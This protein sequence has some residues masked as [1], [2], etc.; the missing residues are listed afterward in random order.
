MVDNPVVDHEDWLEARIAL[1]EMEKE[2]TRLRDRISAHRRALPWEKVE[3]D[4][5]FDGPAGRETLSDLFGECSQLAV[6]HFMFDP[7]WEEG[8]KSCSLA[9]DHYD[10]AVP[11]LRARDVSLVVISKAPLFKLQ[12]FRE[13][14]GWGFKWVSSYENDFNRD[15]H[16]SFTP[17]ERDEGEAYYNYRKG[18]FPVNEAPGL[19]IFAKDERQAAS[20][21][22]IPPMRAGW[23]R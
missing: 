12:A 18:G 7:G 16:V 8:C 17:E 14:M 6:V 13:R 22:P 11:H 4:Y 23:N 20:S 21:T 19:S 9:A 2:Y 5:I 3:K 10:R 15:Y 1:L